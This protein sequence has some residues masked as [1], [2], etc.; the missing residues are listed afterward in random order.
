MKQNREQRPH[1]PVRYL[2]PASIGES[3]WR[4]HLNPGETRL[5]PER[6]G[7]N[8]PTV[9]FERTDHPSS[10]GPRQVRHRERGL[11]RLGW[12]PEEVCDIDAANMFDLS[13]P[14]PVHASGSIVLLSLSHLQGG[15]ET[16]LQRIPAAAGIYAWYQ[17]IELDPQSHLGDQVRRLIRAPHSVSR[18]A[19]MQPNYRVELH[20]F[21]R[22][23]R[24]KDAELDDTL[25]SD[26]DFRDGLFLAA[27]NAILFQRP[28]YIGKARV[29]R[30]RVATHLRPNSKLSRRFKASGIN[31]RE[32]RLLFIVLEPRADDQSYEDE[33]SSYES[34]PEEGDDGETEDQ[35]DSELMLEDVLSRLFHPS[36]T[37]RYG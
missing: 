24:K 34:Q 26:A 17:T 5:G 27:A 10:V 16:V 7:T 15:D 35:T 21:T 30:K 6:R 1:Q 29:L 28:L 3:F 25:A 18:S 23:P 19:N 36:H 32:C 14:G 13:K 2:P 9:R 12:L 4:S 8:G 37:V 31:L 11:P 20:P 22:L 33:P